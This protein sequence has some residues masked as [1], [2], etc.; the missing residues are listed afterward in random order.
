M[1]GIPANCLHIPSSWGSIKARPASPC[2]AHTHTHTQPCTVC[3]SSLP[4]SH[5]PFHCFPFVE[6]PTEVHTLHTL[7]PENRSEAAGE[8]MPAQSLVGW[9]SRRTFP[10]LVRTLCVPNVEKRDSQADVHVHTAAKHTHTEL[11]GCHNT[12]CL[13]AN[14]LVYS[15]TLGRG[16]SWCG[17]F[18]VFLSFF[19][20]QQCI[21]S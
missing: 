1:L 7:F 3:C 18:I 16:Q 13:T 8:K 20:P 21:Q 6:S 10:S 12:Q 19:I 15:F 17:V 2:C 4:P 14:S 5:S 11:S 9:M